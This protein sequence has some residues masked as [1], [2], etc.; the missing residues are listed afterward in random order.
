MRESRRVSER[1]L[2]QL[3]RERSKNRDLLSQLEEVTNSKEKMISQLTAQLS[4]RGKKENT[5]G[6]R[7]IVLS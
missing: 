5:V 2:V 6:D 7:Y 3:T 1:H 4:E